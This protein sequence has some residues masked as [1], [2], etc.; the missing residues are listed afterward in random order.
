MT[1]STPTD[2]IKSCQMFKRFHKIDP[3]TGQSQGISDQ[4]NT[5]PKENET[6]VTIIQTELKAALINIEPV[7]DTGHSQLGM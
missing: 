7:E 6:K 3:F 4:I 2:H 1:N 5:K